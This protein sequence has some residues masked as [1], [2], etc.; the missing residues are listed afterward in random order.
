MNLYQVMVN[1]Y[2]P[3]GSQKGIAFFVVAN[4]NEEVFDYLLQHDRI[5]CK[6]G[7]YWNCWQDIRDDIMDEEDEEI[8]DLFKEEMLEHCDEE[9][10]TR[11]N[12]D[13]LYYG[14]S[15]LSWKLIKE[16]AKPDTLQA[17]TDY[18]IPIFNVLT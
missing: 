3:K 8:E 14:R 4:S 12:Y 18:G 2:A 10:T 7:S 6:H 15:Y 11:A 17:I 13:D 9:C 5:E 1:H 16:D